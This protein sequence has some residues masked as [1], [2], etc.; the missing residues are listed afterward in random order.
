MRIKPS[1]FD[2]WI[3][4][5]QHLNDCFSLLEN[6]YILPSS[7]DKIAFESKDTLY[8]LELPMLPCNADTERQYARLNNNLGYAIRTNYPNIIAVVG[9]STHEHWTPYKEIT[10]KKGGKPV[11]KFSDNP[12]YKRQGHIHTIIAGENSHKIATKLYETEQKYVTKHFPKIKPKRTKMAVRSQHHISISYI[13]WQ[14]DKCRS[15]GNIDGYIE[16]Q[17][18]EVDPLDFEG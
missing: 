5:I 14:S 16:E 12:K 1:E 17:H 18:L 8:R 7:N 6:D 11:K 15:Y 10:T 13:S 4:M 3:K 9:Y 2:K